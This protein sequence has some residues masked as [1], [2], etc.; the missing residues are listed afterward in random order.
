VGDD[1]Q[2]GLRQLAATL[3]RL[4]ELLERLPNSVAKD[5]RERVATLRSILL[6]PR[7]P[8]LALVG[9]RGAGKSSLINALFGKKVAEVGHVKSQTGRGRWFEY[10]EAAGALSILDTRG[11]QEGSAPEEADDAATSLQSIVLELKKKAPDVVVFLVKA[12]EVDSAVEG[13]L[14]A[15]EEVLDEIQRTHKFRPPLL[16]IATHCDLLEPKGTRLHA[17]R[18]EPAEDVEEKLTH[19]AAVERHLETKVR[20][21]GR[22]AEQLAA[23]LGVSTYLSWRADGS[24]RADERWR[25]DD[26]ARLVFRHLPNEGRGVFVRVARARGLQEELATTLTRATAAICAGIAAVPIPIADVVPITTLQGSMIAGIAWVG[27]RALDTKGAAEFL[28]SLGANVGAAFL[29]R[30]AARALV[31]YVFPG[32]GAAVSAAVAFGGTMAVGS[33]ASAY[34]I[35]GVS[36]SE[37]RRL[38]KR[39]K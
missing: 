12:T 19:V 14:A 32:G 20:A 21:R 33:A 24:L 2:N 18:G 30:E 1:P 35:R 38:F 27:G 36:L 13:D 28:A 11:V 34:F 15:L 9:R 17:P 39:G 37:A 22:L 6:E 10:K 4:E 26:L 16:A 8:A 29:F 5:L 25:M 3:S 23:V 7:P 31:K